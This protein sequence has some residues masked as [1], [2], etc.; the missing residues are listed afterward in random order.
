MYSNSYFPSF[1][2]LI[3][4]VRLACPST[5]INKFGSASLLFSIRGSFISWESR[6]F[7]PNW[8]SEVVILLLSITVSIH[9][10]LQ[11]Q[12]QIA[13]H[14]EHSAEFESP[15]YSTCGSKEPKHLHYITGNP[16]GHDWK[17]ET[18]A[19]SRFV[20]C[21]DLRNWEGCFYTKSNVADCVRVDGIEPWSWRE[22]ELACDESYE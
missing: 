1:S 21:N 12:E 8:S 11:A 9:P 3:S 19:G 15:R 14:L 6:I 10:E 2:S 18:F 16:A 20:I 13:A 4:F 17:T 5:H 7:L 22:N